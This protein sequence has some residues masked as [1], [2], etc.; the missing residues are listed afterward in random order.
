MRKKILIPERMG[1]PNNEN[2][3]VCAERIGCAVRAE[4]ARQAISGG[5]SQFSSEK[6]GQPLVKAVQELDKE[7]DELREQLVELKNQMVLIQGK[8][9]SNKQ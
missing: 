9:N 2:F 7:N 5:D 4:G 6:G 1:E 3:S 8:L